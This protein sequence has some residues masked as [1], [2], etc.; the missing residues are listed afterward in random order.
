MFS[1]QDFAKILLLTLCERLH[2][3][4]WQ[5]MQKCQFSPNL[6]HPFILKQKLC[7]EQPIMIGNPDGQW[8]LHI[9][10]PRDS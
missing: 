6:L 2:F 1:K 3:R 7:P 9:D 4:F 5:K 8:L 10:R